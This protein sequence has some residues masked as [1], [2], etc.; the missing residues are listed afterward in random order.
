MKLENVDE[1]TQTQLKVLYEISKIFDNLDADFWLRGGWAIDFMLGKVTRP[2]SD[3]DIK[4][5]ITNRELL[6]DALLKAGYERKP[7]GEEFRNRQSDF[8]KN[9][10]VI[11]IGYLTYDVDGNLIMNGLPEWVWRDDSLMPDYFQLQ[12]IKAKVLHPKQ[13]LEEKK[14]YEEIGRP[15]RIKDE[16]SK[17]LLHQIIS[18]FK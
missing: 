3:I 17:R 4:T 16:K 5:W 12:G 7:V 10:V 14:I 13:L 18:E 1:Q 15:Y 2:H 8:L 6:E 9:N 11:S